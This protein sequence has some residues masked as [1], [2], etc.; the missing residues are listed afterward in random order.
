LDRGSKTTDFR[1]FAAKGDSNP[2]FNRTAWSTNDQQ[3]VPGHLRIG[4]VCI[5]PALLYERFRSDSFVH[6]NPMRHQSP[7]P[8]NPERE[9]KSSLDAFEEA[10]LTP[11][12]SGELP[13]WAQNVKSTW[14]EASAQVSYHVKQLHPRQYEEIAA[15]DPELLPRIEV[16]KQE[17]CA[18]EQRRDELSEA[19]GRVTTH[20]PELEPDEAK[21]ASFTQE[22]IDSSIQFIASV[23][24][25]SLAV[26]TWFSEAF[27]R[28]R[29]AVD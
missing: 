7:T 28:D 9:L 6:S 25:Q 14:A 15:Q 3:N 2:T 21:A 13:A 24:K 19:I 11:I 22:L 26:Q 29:G 1:W 27:T 10:L 16:L 5:L 4:A 17:D 20:I 12:V 8:L 18:L 23:R